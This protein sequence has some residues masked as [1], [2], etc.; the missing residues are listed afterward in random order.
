MSFG[1]VQYDEAER[2]YGEFLKKLPEGVTARSVKPFD[3]IKAEVVGEVSTMWDP[4]GEYPPEEGEYDDLKKQANDAATVEDLFALCRDASWDLWGAAPFIAS[5][6]F[7]EYVVP[8]ELPAGNAEGWP[9]MNMAIIGSFS[10]ET[11]LACALLVREG[12]VKDP[13]CFNDFS[14]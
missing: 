6:V 13:S 4:E 10:A 9:V 14:T 1:S 5:S 7:E 12:I 3:A 8:D 11:G 2:F